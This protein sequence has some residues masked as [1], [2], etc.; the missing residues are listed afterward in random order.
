MEAAAY[1]VAQEALTNV[2]RHAGSPTTVVRLSYQFDALILHVDD[3]G[4]GLAANGPPHAGGGLT[5]IREQVHTVGGHLDAGPK[6][7]GGLPVRAWIPTRP[8]QS[9]ASY[10]PTTRRWSGPGFAPCSTPKTTSPCSPKPPT[11]AQAVALTR[12]HRPDVVLMDIRMPGCDGLEATR[13]ITA[14]DRLADVHVV[15]LTTFE[16]DEY[17]FEAI[18]AGASGF[19]VK[20]T[21]PSE[22]LRALRAVAGGDALLSP[23][24]TRRLI[25]AFATG[26][27]SPT[28]RRPSTGS[29]NVNAKSWPSSRKAI[30]TTRSPND[31]SSAPPLLRRTSTGR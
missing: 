7:E 21:E 15:L 19:L 3:N 12:E 9:S 23:G 26:S 11:V 28:P 8:D 25:E 13:R 24:A 17:V 5:G 31:S 22:L 14:D 27:R 2:V 30:A 1:R 29:P 16:L 4:A 20:D 18:R 10:S 6:P